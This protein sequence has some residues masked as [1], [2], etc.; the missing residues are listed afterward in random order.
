MG[1]IASRYILCDTFPRKTY[2]FGLRGQSLTD[3]SPSKSPDFPLVFKRLRAKTNDHPLAL[4]DREIKVPRLSKQ[5]KILR[6]FD[7]KIL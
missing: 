3:I 2:R 4:Q 6:F 1:S 5:F 7:F